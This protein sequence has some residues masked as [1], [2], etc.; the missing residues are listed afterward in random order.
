MQF[1]DAEALFRK[2]KSHFT[3]TLPDKCITVQLQGHPFKL[4]TTDL[5]HFHQNSVDQVYYCSTTDE[6]LYMIRTNNDSFGL[7][8][9]TL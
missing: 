4:P 3:E 7:N 6:Q 8:T 9:L 1:R 5:G 2:H